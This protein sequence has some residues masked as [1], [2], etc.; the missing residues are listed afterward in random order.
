MRFS[1]M[2]LAETLVPAVIF[3]TGA[4]LFAAAVAEMKALGMTPVLLT[5]DQENT[6]RAGLAASAI[7]MESEETINPSMSV[8]QL[9]RR[10]ETAG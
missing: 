8:E 3:L 1:W 9:R 4:G 10:L 6:A 7:A 5:G 2:Q